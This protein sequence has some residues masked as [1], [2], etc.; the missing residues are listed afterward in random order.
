MKPNRIMGVTNREALASFQIIHFFL[1]RTFIL[2]SYRLRQ[3][4]HLDIYKMSIAHYRL[5][6]VI[7]DPYYK[8]ISL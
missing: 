7:S 5:D 8:R 1:S 4:T 3:M 6:T 2:Y